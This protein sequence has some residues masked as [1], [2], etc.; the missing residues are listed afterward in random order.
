[1]DN[2]EIDWMAA[3]IRPGTPVDIKG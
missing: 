1:M 2:D 3:H